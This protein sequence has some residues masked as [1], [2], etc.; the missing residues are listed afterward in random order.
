VYVT[1][2]NVSPRALAETSQ[3]SKRGLRNI[4]RERTASSELLDDEAESEARRQKALYRALNDQWEGPGEEDWI[5][6]LV[7]FPDEGRDN[8]DPQYWLGRGLVLT[9]HGE[10][11]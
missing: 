1:R 10:Q 4:P 2:S 8:T 7:E 3:A 9:Q 5:R 11:A 6:E